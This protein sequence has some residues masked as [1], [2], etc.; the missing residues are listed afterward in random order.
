MQCLKARKG[1]AL[2][3]A[4]IIMNVMLMLFFAMILFSVYV[5][6][7]M[8]V[9]FAA[10]LAIDEAIGKLPEPGMLPHKVELLMKTSAS[11]ALNLGI[12]LVDKSVVPRITVPSSG[13]G[14]GTI[15]ITVSAK[16]SI[17]MPFVSTFLNN[18]VLS[19]TSIVDY[20]WG[21]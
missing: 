11:G 10:N 12:F 9:V 4:V 3:E 18:N 2:I 19:H 21:T 13:S 16:Y 14:S 5:Y 6:D 17:H 15:R 20:S 1:Q 7:K 8:I